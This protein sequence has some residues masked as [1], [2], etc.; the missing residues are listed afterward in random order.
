M[1]EL[2]CRL[3]WQLAVRDSSTLPSSDKHLALTLLTWMNEH[4]RCDPGV[5]AIGKGMSACGYSADLTHAG[6]TEKAAR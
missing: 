3:R 5:A 2:P 6:V 4:G 1:T